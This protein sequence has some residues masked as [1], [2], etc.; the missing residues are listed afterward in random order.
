MTVE[1]SSAFDNLDEKITAMGGVSSIWPEYKGYLATIVCLNLGDP[2]SGPKDH[3][4]EDLLI[5]SSFSG[6]ADT[7]LE[8]L[9]IASQKFFADVDLSSV[10]AKQ[11]DSPD[12]P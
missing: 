7:K 6:A 8:A 9:Q 11:P 12:S 2:V 10:A 5:T 3:G 4:A 1:S